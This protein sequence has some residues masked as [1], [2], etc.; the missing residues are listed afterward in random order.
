MKYRKLGSTNLK[1]SEVSLGTMTFGEQTSKKEAFA[2]MD[3]SFDQGI[4][5][6]DTAEM[7]PVFPKKNTQGLSEKIIGEWL[8]SRKLKNKVL[9]GTKI[10]CYNP[11]FIGVTNLPWLR[12]GHKKLIFNKKNFQEA[13]NLSLKRLNIE[14]IDIYQLHWP[15]RNVPI[16]GRLDYEHDKK[17]NNWTKIHEIIDVLKDLIK[18]GKIL[19]FGLSNETPWG[20]MKFIS[21]S[22]KKKITQPVTIQ[23]AYNLLNRVYDISHSEISMR[24]NIGLLAYSPLASGRLTG[25]Y[26]DG[27]IPIKSRFSIWPGRF[28]R[29]FT[30]KGEIAIQKYKKL[31]KEFNLKPNILAHAFVLSRPFLSSNIMG[32]TTLDQIKENLMSLRINLSKEI[33][34]KINEIHNEERNPCL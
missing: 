20:M 13:I 6:F 4:N 27:K 26:L 12:G 22:K 19:N 5:F 21:E 32:V 23:N 11:K 18:E 34:N 25:K 2:I 31:A 1:I 8:K 24:E 10:A 16:F 9:I 30:K 15:E 17:D 14:C 33:I 3:Y 7:Y 29:H 28:D